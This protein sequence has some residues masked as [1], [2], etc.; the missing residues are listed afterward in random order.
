MRGV[1]VV[2]LMEARRHLPFLQWK[3]GIP[4]FVVSL[5]LALSW[6]LVADEGL[7]PGAGMFVAELGGE[8]S[9]A[10]AL[11]AANA[12]RVVHGDGSL[13]EAGKADLFIVGMNVLHD[14]GDE[15]SRAAA[16]AFDRAVTDHVEARL[17]GETDLDAA[18]PVRVRLYYETRDVVG[19]EMK[20]DGGSAPTPSD[21]PPRP[22]Y[23]ENGK[24][25]SS[26]EATAGASGGE[27]TLAQRSGSTAEAPLLPDDIEPPFPIRSLLLTF[28]FVIPWSFL[29]QVL[30]GSILHERLARR[31]RLL[32]STPWSGATLLAGLTLP[33][34]VMALLV[35]VGVAWWTGA[36]WLGFLAMMPVLFV[37]FTSATLVGLLARTQREMTF[38]LVAITTGLATFLFLPAMFI[39]VHPIAFA[40]PVAVV[41]SAV[42]DQ[43]VPLAAFLYATLPLTLAG[44]AMAWLGTALFRE[45]HL[46]SPE[47][48]LTKT[49]DGMQHLVGPRWKLLATG[50]LVVPFALV[51]ELFV[52]V[53]AV[54]L[55]LHV[56]FI[57]FVFGAAAIE[58]LLKGLPAYAH[59]ERLGAAARPSWVVG[60]LLGAGFFLG[61]KIALLIA[62]AG[63]GLLPQ[64]DAALLTFGL[65]AGALLFVAPLVLHM[66]TASVTASQAHKGK[67]WAIGGWWMAV[68]I[69]V[70]YNV[71]I[72][73]G[74]LTL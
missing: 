58:E 32:L 21:S 37:L 9:Y 2:G 51:L 43:A 16:A 35:A 27:R 65:G 22:P 11:Y 55:E 3:T 14:E 60:G 7:D 68:L 39:Q 40:S 59:R 8:S 5:A 15:R 42:R 31:G 28:A 26:D 29:A 4:M 46:F 53:I 36:G 1:F 41:S 24:T 19:P 69:H 45:E 47:G 62:L 30:S 34:Y 64:G 17:A 67:R 20:Q 66:A 63:F 74:G 54:M 72:V 33:Y 10:D 38:L 12:F 70:T 52:L 23:A 56:A 48:L 73:L 57:L 6:P 49:V 50:V 13:Y 44:V 61:E 18:Y 71:F 25:A